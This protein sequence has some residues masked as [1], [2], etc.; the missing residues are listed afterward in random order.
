MRTTLFL[1]YKSIVGNKKKSL[2]IFLIIS[3]VLI[4][5]IVVTVIKTN[6]LNYE[7]QTL[8]IQ[9]GSW[10]IIVPISQ[11]DVKD[12]ILNLKSVSEVATVRR[13][14]VLADEKE[15]YDCYFTDSRDFGLLINKNVAGEIPKNSNEILVPDWYLNKYGITKLPFTV[16][17]G[18]LKLKITGSYITTT[19]NVYNQNVKIYF[20]S[21]EMSELF[22]DSSY[23][24]SPYDSI[25][26][27]NKDTIFAYI[28]FNIGCNIDT[29]IT[30]IKNIFGVNSFEFSDVTSSDFLDEVIRNEELL[31][32]EGFISSPNHKDNFINDNISLIITAILLIVLF[33][34][35]FVAMNL[36]ISGDVRLCGILQALGV[37]NKSIIAIYLLQSLFI[38]LLSVPFG[39]GLGSLGAYL[40]LNNSLGKIHGNIIFPLNDIIACLVSCIVFV[41]LAALYP[42]IKASKV[43]CVD[44]ISGRPKK[45]KRELKKFNRST[46]TK[47]Q[48]KLL[49]A[50]RYSIRNISV[51][52]AK[53]FAFIIS[54]SL[55]LSVFIRLSSEIETM[56]KEGNWRQSYSSDFVIGYDRD[57]EPDAKFIDEEVLDSIRKI[58]SIDNIYYQYSIDDSLQEQTEDM[59][60]Y[61]FKVDKD[62]VTEQGYK[63]LALSSPITRDGY[64]DELFIQAGISG[65]G[66]KELNLALNYLIDGSV[67]VEQMK[68]ENIILLPKYILWLENLDVPY[69][70]LQVGDKITIVENSS[71]SLI[72]IDIVEEYTFTIGGFVDALPL[73]QVNGVSN[74]FVAIMYKDNL[75]QFKTAYKG[76]AEIYLDGSNDTH[77]L[78]TM[79]KLCK[80]NKL[81]FTDYT[82]DFRLQEKEQKQ[83]MLM[84]SFYAIFTAL[85]LVVF[86]SIFNVLLSNIM[87]RTNEFSLLSIIGV[88]NWQRNLSIIMEILSF[89][90]PSIILGVGAG[91]ALI[92]SGDMS[93]EI[94]NTYQLVP[95]NH[96]LISTSVI[97]MAMFL[98]TVIG[99]IY[100]N[101]NISVNIEQI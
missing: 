77:T 97:G 57:L 47:S 78:S 81:G 27:D 39:G 51:N 99:I 26:V 54:I 74:G 100:I 94:L 34:T 61:Y 68:N 5:S 71:P 96:I 83:K 93:S 73:P 75:R 64:N 21:G 11:E 6:L 59:Y 15:N 31:A 65:Y 87:L 20:S 82:N 22:N 90:L 67:T 14:L 38:S 8:K 52:K 2:F 53:I 25:I 42:A 16:T 50:L 58:D 101:K 17:V 24:T 60:D 62:I 33:V 29:A 3:I 36:I 49:F 44:A 91:I 32:S 48:S 72:N 84:I 10:H 18:S 80:D 13:T 19:D 43:I 9:K 86:L 37:S 23:T 4:M 7:T 79:E 45:D 35:I 1:A 40:L 95:I 70:N 88:R 63:Q 56:W 46:F 28:R 41:I 76:I 12:D 89:A 66:E 55:L 98:S 69:T 30:Q 85:G 92:L